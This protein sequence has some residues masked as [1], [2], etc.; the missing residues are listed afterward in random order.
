MHIVL[1]M[2]FL[3]VQG[4]N[5]LNLYFNFEDLTFINELDEIAFS[6]AEGG[7]LFKKAEV[8]AKKIK[9]IKVRH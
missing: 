5:V 3:I 8:S 6:L 9:Q 1:V 7:F 2:F 4:E